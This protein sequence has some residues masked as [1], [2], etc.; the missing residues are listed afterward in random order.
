MSDELP[1]GW[2][3][4][5][6]KEV[7]SRPRSKVVPSNYPDLPFIG[8][9]H[10]AQDGMEL[11]GSVPFGTM[12]SS[13][14]MF[15][16]GDVLYGRMRP[17]L[18]KVHRAKT[19]GAC[20]AEFIVLPKSEAIDSDFL[21]YTLHHRKFVNFAS[22]QSSGDRPRVDFDALS[23]YELSLPPKSE[24]SRIVSK[25][26]E[27]FSRIDEGERALERVQKLVERY[28]QSVLKAAVTGELTR[29]WR[30]KQA[31]SG[32]SIENGEALLARILTA[33]R[34]AWEQAELDKMKAK[35]LK[36]KDDKWKQKYASPSPPDTT[37]LPE[38]PEGWVWASIG[39]L[40]FRVTKGSSPGWQGF[41]YLPAGVPF[42]RSQ[43][44]GWGQLDL[45]GIAYVDKSFN[46][47][48]TKSIIK[49]GDVLLNIV[50][51]SVGRAAIA[52]EAIQGANS[53]QAVAGIRPVDP[54]STGEFLAGYLLSPQCQKRIHND[55]VDVAR[56]NFNLNQIVELPIAIPSSPEMEAIRVSLAS[57]KVQ[58]DALVGSLEFE[59]KRATSLRQSILRAAFSG[60]LVAQDSND[61]SAEI[62]MK[63]IAAERC[64]AP[65]KPK[66][67]KNKK[68]ASK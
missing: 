26:D 24:Q 61:E 39:Q 33:R 34:E 64:A 29:E 55:K 53:N 42:V 3:E 7:V 5:T 67:A 20:S 28:R 4:T 30:E 35:G 38:L 36:P 31:K 21:A 12:K 6:L 52:T 50:G 66:R 47:V 11:L 56:A 1:P 45:E 40:S 44:V 10:I 54:E 62:L 13:G 68:K 51:A 17:Y 23:N 15:F 2:V 8:M 59:M 60:K 46:D 14:G 43:N 48:E 16:E 49:K 18:N 27:L 63:R 37:D 65:A 25:I 9:D 57:S 22:E 58:I 19:K 32:A 41:E